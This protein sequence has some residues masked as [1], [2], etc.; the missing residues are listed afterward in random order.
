MQIKI[1][2]NDS[3]PAGDIKINDKKIVNFRCKF[4]LKV[5]QISEKNS[6]K[7]SIPKKYDYYIYPSNR[8]FKENLIDI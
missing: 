1:S 8:K 2:E 4:F 7:L 6:S 5:L 3:E